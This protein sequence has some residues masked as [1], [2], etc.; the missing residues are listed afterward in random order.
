MASTAELSFSHVGLYV[1]DLERM[2]DFYTRVLG[3]V[4]TDR[5]NLG[6]RRL[7]FLSRDPREHHQV[8]LA[9]GRHPDLDVPVLNQVSFRVS[10]LAELQDFYRALEGE[11][12]TDL[13]PTIHGNAWSLY[14]RDPEKNRLEVFADSDWYISQPIKE[15]LDLTLPEAE[16]RRR[17]REFCQ[18]R[19]GFQPVEQ[20]RAAMADKMRVALEA[21]RA[22]RS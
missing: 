15:P 6:P 14:F 4:V 2:V 1:L 8:V 18:D 12:V 10:T 21:R 16:I 20:W 13:D 19:P 17:T 11:P 22:A 9:T 5:G 7:A 3:F